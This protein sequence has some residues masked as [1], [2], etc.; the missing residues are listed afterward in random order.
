[1]TVKE[2]L[3][4]GYRLEQRIRLAKAEIEELR[5]MTV[6]IS[7]PGFEEHFNPNRS[8]EAPYE[9]VLCKIMEMEQE[10]AQRLHDLLVFKQE[11]ISVINTLDDKDERLILHYRYICN[12]NWV[13]I[14]E[15]LGWDARTVRRWHNKAIA[16]VT[17]PENPVVVDSFLRKNK[18]GT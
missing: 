17:M 8:T 18:N 1:M 7:S 9:K 10:Q 2:Y 12:M 14:G 15:H 11:L 5:E 3:G 4:Q 6:S 13:Q 16:H